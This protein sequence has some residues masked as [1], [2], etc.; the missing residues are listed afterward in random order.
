MRTT[1]V[2]FVNA[3]YYC[4]YVFELKA[5]SLFY[6]ILDIPFFPIYKYLLT[7]TQRKRC[8][9]QMEQDKNQFRVFFHNKKDGFPPDFWAYK[10]L[11]ALPMGYALFFTLLLSSLASK[12]AGY[13]N[14]TATCTIFAIMMLLFYIPVYRAVFTNDR[15][16]KYFK[17]FKKKDGR[18]YRK[19]KWITFA[20]FIGSFTL[21]FL[22]IFAASAI[23]D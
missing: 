19:W 21:A 3:I 4:L 13:L 9:E 6:K 14:K 15:R 16:Q 2:Y 10:L 22:S 1:Y 5:D 23:I 7:E 17:K 20:L 12:G 8:A 18:W 11:G